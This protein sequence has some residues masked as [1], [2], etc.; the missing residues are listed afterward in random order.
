MTA[1]AP[2]AGD[3][4]GDVVELVPCAGALADGTAR[5][6]E[7]AYHPTVWLPAE[8]DRLRELFARDEP[9]AAI[10]GSVGRTFQ[11]TRNRVCVLGLR[12]NSAR[13]WLGEEDAELL[14]RY[15][16]ESAAA[17][18]SD[19][20]R[21]T[22]AVY[23]RANLLGV[24]EDAAADYDSW[25]DAQIRA[26]YEREVPVAQIAALIGRPLLGVRS[27]ATLLGLR[28]ASQ[29]PGWSDAEVTRAL[30]LAEDG[31]PYR[32]IVV[33]L[34]REGF[35]ARSPRAFGLHVRKLGYGRGWGRDW[36][37]EEEDLLR[38]AY[39][40]GR[41]IAQLARRMGRGRSSVMWKAGELG[42]HGTHRN[43]AGW[44]TERCWTD[45]DE[46]ILRAEYG[47]TPNAELARKLDRKWS[48]C[49]VRANNLGLQHGWMRA[50][51]AAED[52][53]LLIAWQEGLSM[54]DVAAAMQRDPAVVGKRIRRVWGLAFN[55]PQRPA[56]GPR[57]PR[58]DREPLT[59]DAILAMEDA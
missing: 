53:A 47:K 36:T 18:A 33:T 58:A 22:G 14:A 50:F 42:L 32:K 3:L 49:R 59:L 17:I 35:P 25:E 4:R 44:R 34:A 23:A 48:A 9:I 6:R 26:G 40:E 27:R 8:D 12:R 19:L 57:T 15:G 28:H 51:T 5:V 37:G 52:D 16:E 39:A 55:D 13:P 41:S 21:S 31:H 46:A 10:A 24:T 43:K 38:Q 54:V 7:V 11:A 56:R 29:P 45:E 2:L 20:G 30:E 1:A